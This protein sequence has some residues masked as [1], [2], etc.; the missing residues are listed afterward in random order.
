MSRAERLQEMIWL[1]LQRGYSDIEMAERLGVDRTTVFR[2]RSELETE[3]GFSQDDQGRYRLERMQYMPNIKVNLHEALA[4]YLAT[5]RASRQTRIAQPHT[6]SALE[7]LAIALKQ[8]MTERLA[9]AA[10]S[11]LEQSADPERVHVLEVITQGWAEQRKVSITHRALKAPHPRPAPHP[12]P[13]SGVAT[14]RLGRGGNAPQRREYV[15]CPYLIEPSLWSDGAYVIGYCETFQKVA[16]FKI[17]RIEKAELKLER[18]DI[19]EDFDEV[20]LLRYAW[21]IWYGENEP[22]TVRLR[23]AAGEAARRVKESIWHP[24]Q[25]VQDLEDGGVIWQAQV[26]EWLEMLPWVRG[27]GA[28]VEVLEPEGL[29]ESVMG[30]IR[31]AAEIY[32]LKMPDGKPMFYAHSNQ[33]DKSRW[34]RLNDHLEN[35]ASLAVEFG[36]DA[37][38]SELAYISALFHDIGKYSHK[39]QQKLEG[40]PIKVDHSTA[41]AKEVSYLFRNNQTETLM[42]T[43]LAYCITGHHGGLPDYGSAIDVDTDGTLFA[44]LKKEVEDYSYYAQEIDP[45]K[46]SLPN[47]LPIKPIKGFEGFSIAFLTRML[48]SILVDA[49][50]QETETF[51]NKGKKP[52]GGYD[53]IQT[54]HQ[55]L[56]LFLE[57]FQNPDNPI[58]QQRTETLR[59]CIEKATEKP[60]FFT[61]TVPTGGG[62]TLSSLAFAMEHAVIHDLK[63]IIYVIPYTSII[64]QNA[65][66]FKECLGSENVLEHHSN[67]DWSWKTRRK[68][69]EAAEDKTYNSLEKLKLAAENWDIPIVVTTNVQFFESLFANRSSGCRKLHNIVKSVIIFDEAQMLPREYLK[70]CLYAVYELVRNYGASAVFCTATQPSV[71]KFLPAGTELKELSPDPKTLYSFYKRVEVKKLGKLPDVEL[72]ERI[73]D[74]PQVLCIVNTRKHAKGLFEGVINE[75][76]F[77]L[78]TLMCPAHRKETIARIKKRLANGQPC[79][80]ISTQIM[81]AGID[82]DF[83]VGYRA[84]SGLESIIQAAGRVNREGK[85]KIG[86]LY[87][88]EAETAMIKRIPISIKQGAEFSRSILQNYNDPISMEAIEQY[89]NNLYDVQSEQAFDVKR[90]INH[91]HKETGELDFDFRTVADKFRLIEENTES[92]IIPYDEQAKDLL[93]QVRLSDF[94]AWYAR[95]LQPYT[96]NIY[97]TEYEALESK[98]VIDRYSEMYS[99]LNNM[100]FYDAKSGLVLP[101]RDGG[102]AIFFDG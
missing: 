32:G 47:R 45:T 69:I 12:H 78:S 61:L 84:I 53:G 77:H 5:R 85:A 25:E 2:D 10:G 31:A 68:E 90:I 42:A 29:R 96:V 23:F 65:A 27:W 37:G 14:Q 59:A 20:E 24:T 75:G 86:T 57:R 92:I 13:R 33:W 66:V 18:F 87:V 93:E 9:R 16:T 101:D 11:I 56:T 99:V 64:E 34:Q 17:E 1:Y 81:E 7:K 51:M 49:D 28:D 26:A 8:P 70:P 46:L 97:E 73:N 3:H 43:I 76:G 63:R 39:F 38:L 15:V 67:F 4:L 48:Y 71:E 21:G 98:G 88:F 55:K 50:F 60:G 40:K 44:R 82:V 19:P 52:R 95:K 79:R 74:H 58:R 30:D 80:V 35:T 100:D 102:A 72:L 91:F 83:Q 36:R 22:V 89:Y 6:A 41:G 62:K 94:P 54:L